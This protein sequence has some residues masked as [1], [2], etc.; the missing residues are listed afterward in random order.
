MGEE[1]KLWGPEKETTAVIVSVLFLETRCIL[2]GVEVVLILLCLSGP[3][4]LSLFDL[5][6]P[7]HVLTSDYD[8]VCTLLTHRRF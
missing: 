3:I 4:G 2:F 7:D 8:T 6:Q 1:P 5:P